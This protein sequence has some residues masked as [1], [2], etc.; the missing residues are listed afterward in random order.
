MRLLFV[1]LLLICFAN[2]TSYAQE[3]FTIKQ[4][5]VAVKVNKDASLDITETINVHFTE[6][7]HGI[8]RMI[9]F[10]YSMQPL[11]DGMEKADRQMESNGYAHTFIE[12]I[13]VEGWNYSVSEEWDYKKIKIGSANQYVDGDQQY[14]IHYK[15]LNAINF[16]KDRSELYFNVIG[17]KWPVSIENVSFTIEPYDALPATPDYFVATGYTGSKNNNTTSKW[18]SN[19]VFSGS[20]TQ[21]LHAYQAVTIGIVFPKDFLIQP[22]YNLR[23]INWL[24]L[25]AITLFLMFLIWRKWGK[26]ENITVQTEFYPPAGASPSVAGYII[27]DKL[28]RRDLTALIPFWGAGGYLQVKE[29]EKSALL[30]ILKNKD[31]EFTKLKELPENAMVFERTLFKGIFAAGDVTTVKYKQI[32]IA[33]GEGAK[34]ALGAFDYL[35]KEY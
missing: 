10:K 25:P 23:G 4:Y 19:K 27:D 24:A 3:Y 11:P 12:D 2:N 16:F 9:P 31:Y 26:E 6:P 28:D 30:G 13:D 22:N 14:I 21:E 5:N 18:S 17:D 8:F 20:T 7:R 15:L 32:I 35:I 29:I 34:A 33:M 1:T